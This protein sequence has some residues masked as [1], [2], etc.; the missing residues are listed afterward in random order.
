MSLCPFGDH[1]PLQ[2]AACARQCISAK[3]GASAIVDAGRRLA[4]GTAAHC[5]SGMQL[6][7]KVLLECKPAVSAETEIQVIQMSGFRTELHQAFRGFAMVQGKRVR[8]FMESNLG[9]AFI[10]AFQGWV[11]TIFIVSQAITGDYGGSSSNGCFTVYV[12]EDRV[13]EVH[14]GQGQDPAILG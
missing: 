9:E 12:G 13:T 11:G 5:R 14:G 10:V 2:L 3:G 1:I 8:H 6:L 7:P 4:V